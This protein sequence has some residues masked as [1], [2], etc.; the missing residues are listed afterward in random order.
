[1]EITQQALASIYLGGF[2][3]PELRLSGAAR[4]RTAGALGR[5]DL[6]FSTPRAPWNATWF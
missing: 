2:R 5:L 4:E 6:M 3:L 1:V